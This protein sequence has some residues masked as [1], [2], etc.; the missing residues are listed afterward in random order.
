MNETEKITEHLFYENA[1]IFKS[2]FYCQ[3][4]QQIKATFRLLGYES[5][6]PYNQID[7]FLED[8][9]LNL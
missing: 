4:Q 8:T 9:D 3:L 7:I 2:I 6:F 1:Y 5:Y